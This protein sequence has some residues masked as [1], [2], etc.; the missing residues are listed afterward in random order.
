MNWNSLKEDTLISLIEQQPSIWNVKSEDYHKSHVKT[1]A[2]EH[3]VQN[4]KTIIPED[5]SQINYGGSI[6]L[7]SFMIMK[8]ISDLIFQLA[9]PNGPD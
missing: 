8:H 7:I 2:Y 3:I 1:P 5:D 6:T 4:L 9:R